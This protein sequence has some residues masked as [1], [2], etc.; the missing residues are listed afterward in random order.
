MAVE[1]L[2]KNIFFHRADDD[3]KDFFWFCC[4]I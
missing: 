1:A 4:N 3:N 2:P